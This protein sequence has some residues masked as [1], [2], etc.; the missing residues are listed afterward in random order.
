MIN[1]EQMLLPNENDFI[2]LKESRNR[3]FRFAYIGLTV[4]LII[5]Y[6]A[7][8]DTSLLTINHSFQ[9][10]LFS[11]AVFIVVMLMLKLLGELNTL[12]NKFQAIEL[13]TEKD[14]LETQK[15]M[16][17]GI[18]ND[19]KFYLF[20]ALAGIPAV[21]L[22]LYFVKFA[23]LILDKHHL[24]HYI[25]INFLILFIFI[26]FLVCLFIYY[27]HLK[28]GNVVDVCLGIIPEITL[29]L[30][31]VILLPFV[32]TPFIGNKAFTFVTNVILTN[33]SRI[34]AMNSEEL[35]KT[36]KKREIK[37]GKFV[38]PI[39]QINVQERSRN[40]LQVSIVTTSKITRSKHAYSYHNKF[41]DTVTKDIHKTRKYKAV[42]RLR[43]KGTDYNVQLLWFRLDRYPPISSA[44]SFGL[45]LVFLM[46]KTSIGKFMKYVEN[47]LE[48]SNI[49]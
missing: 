13:L 41:V 26:A 23:F 5:I 6:F 35:E 39:S 49:N 14:A 31:F 17:N 33:T 16:R 2:L 10:G 42:K 22:F 4:A 46:Q 20:V 28:K 40:E 24:S 18:F 25:L 15:W 3:D 29:I 7:F 44:I 47:W 34:S 48:K 8:N 32:V 43:P 45:I 21:M 37:Q 11:F 9:L 30:I 27:F 1:S 12:E 38:N 36:I 19:L